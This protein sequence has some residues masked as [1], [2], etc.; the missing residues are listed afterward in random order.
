MLGERFRRCPSARSRSSCTAARRSSTPPSRCCRSSSAPQPVAARRYIV[1]RTSGDTIH[2]L[3]PRRA[4]RA[5][6]DASRARP[7]CCASAPA[8]LYG[9]IVVGD[10]NPRLRG[11]RALRWAWLGIGAAECFSGRT[12]HARAI[13]ARRLREGAPPSFP[14]GAARRVAA[15]R[16]GRRPRRP[17]A[18]RRPP[19]SRSSARPAPRAAP[20]RT[21]CARRSTAARSTTPRRPGAPTSPRWAGEGR[22]SPAGPVRTGRWFVSL[23]LRRS[24]R[25]PGMTTRR[26]IEPLSEWM[27][28]NGRLPVA[29]RQ[30]S[31]MMPPWTT[32][33]AVTFGPVSATMR[34]QA[35]ADAGLDRLGRL[36]VAG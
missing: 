23:K 28:A 7:S 31:P 32:A 16:H 20:P 10:A 24:R 33:A 5:R 4:A 14:P 29:R 15:R 13:V 34:S 30:S 21:R 9:R 6:D 35:G 2:V 25:P 27:N 12:R 8:A 3:A 11:W 19:R 26:L 18:G 36:A 1:G 22:V 17:R